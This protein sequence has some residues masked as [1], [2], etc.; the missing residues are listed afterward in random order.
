MCSSIPGPQ[1]HDWS[2]RETPNRLSHPVAPQTPFW[3]SLALLPPLCLFVYMHTRGR[4]AVV[5]DHVTYKTENIDFDPLQEKFAS[6][7]CSQDLVRVS[8]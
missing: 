5:T 8:S 1:D 4:V 2:Q 7:E 3:T 6:L